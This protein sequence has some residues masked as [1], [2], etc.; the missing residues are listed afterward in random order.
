MKNKKSIIFSII[1]FFAILLLS[2]VCM[3]KDLDIINDY[4][5]T[6]D[7][8]LDGT[9]DISYN[10]KWEVLDSTSEGPLTWVKIGIPNSHVDSIRATSS[11]IKSIR[12]Y[13]DGGDYV[14]IDFTKEYNAGEIVD[15]GF[16][17]HQSYMYTLS[18]SKCVY[19]F[20]PGWFGT[21][22][23]K[24]I[25]VY[26]NSDKVLSSTSKKTNSDN[27]LVWSGSLGK[28]G[29]LKT[30]VTYD[31]NTFNV[32]TNKQYQETSTTRN[33]SSSVDS[34]VIL[35]YII[36]FISVFASLLTPFAGYG[37]R[38]HG[39]YGYRSYGHRHSYDRSIRS[40]SSYRSSCVSSCACACACAGGGR[41]GCSKKDLYGTNLTTKNIAKALNED[42]K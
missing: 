29:K 6:V 22:K 36:I 19:N 2:N 14:R 13:S 33:S 9:L 37:Y 11:N 26:W 35:L 23:V 28:G 15:F 25:D 39:G 16:S 17:L 31:I 34:M 32:D 5:I 4:S 38:R 27:Y 20:T 21:L 1:I 12:Y 42:K 41:A 30:Q 10:I 40:S 7:P 3:A 18:G 24:N 8:R